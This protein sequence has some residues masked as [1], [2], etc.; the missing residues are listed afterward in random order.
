MKPPSIRKHLLPGALK[1]HANFWQ[2]LETTQ[3]LAVLLRIPQHKLQLESLSQRYKTYTIPKKNGKRRLIEDPN[4]QLKKILRK[5]NHFLQAS[6]YFLRPASVHGFCISPKHTPPRTILSNARTHLGQPYLLNLDLQDFFHLISANRVH[7]ILARQFPK[8]NHELQ[9]LLVRLLTYKG[10]LPMGAPTSPAMSNFASLGLDHDLEILAQNCGWKYSRFVDDL[11][12]SG[13]Q[14][15]SEDDDYLIRPVIRQ[16]GFWVNEEKVTQYGRDQEKIVTGLHLREGSVHLPPD[17][18]PQLETEIARLHAVMLV[19]GR[20]QTGMSG[21][22]LKML[23]QELLGKLNFAGQVLGVSAPEFQA[24]EEQYAAA[25][26]AREDYESASWL[27]IP[28][29]VF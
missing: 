13:G 11:S 3:D 19:E 18:L 15:F 1:R 14:A 21:R 22:K 16:H 6:Y 4:P 9:Q 2:H 26:S 7:R 27:D 20:Y 5:V 17:Y 25:L 12:F 24:R 8:M 23:Q 28:Y 29:E 10:R